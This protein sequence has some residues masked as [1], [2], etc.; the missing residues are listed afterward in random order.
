MPRS[1]IEEMGEIGALCAEAG[2]QEEFQEVWNTPDT[3]SAALRAVRAA[4]ADRQDE[5]G[6][7]LTKAAGWS[8][9][10]ARYTPPKMALSDFKY[11]GTFAIPDAPEWR[12][13]NNTDIVKL[14][15]E[16]AFLIASNTYIRKVT[17]PDSL[18]SAKDIAAAP[19]ATVDPNL[20]LHPG[21][22]IKPKTTVGSGYRLGAM[23]MLDWDLWTA[24]YEFYNVAGRDH[25]GIVP[26]DSFTLRGDAGPY[27]VENAYRV[28]PAGV[29]WPCASIASLNCSQ[30]RNPAD[31]EIFHYNKTTGGHLCVIDRSWAE[32]HVS[33]R[34]LGCGRHRGAG[35]FGG[36]QGP[37]LYAFHDEQQDDGTLGG[38]PLLVYP[39]GSGYWPG[40]KN[41][42]KS[43][44]S[45]WIHDPTTGRRALLVGAMR[46]EGADYYGPGPA[47]NADK[48]WHSEPYHPSW[49][50]FDCDDLAQVAAGNKH[51]W[52]VQPYEFEDNPSW[53]W[54]L[55]TDPGEDP[56]C[57]W[58]WFS[59]M[60][61]DPAT[62]TLYVLQPKIGE[63]AGA[64]KRRVVVHV[65][66]LL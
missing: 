20:G 24:S 50:L 23:T 62:R 66:E 17:P 45:C 59:G 15:D 41:D 44:Y 13:L 29:S 19:L 52:D 26:V 31:L 6:R 7:V 25:S 2:V 32:D 46:G 11:R 39:T 56:N 42:E 60:H 34:R 38:M 16:D 18:V 9:P 35:A 54:R 63:G 51:P 40:Y 65:L 21:T 12:N 47:C 22:W 37:I 5:L 58:P 28:G 30:W 55:P 53:L 49:Y 1:L 8:A 14:P 3:E 64:N 43:Y 33:G 27:D 4:C 61:F 10:P 36:A 57:R 48:G